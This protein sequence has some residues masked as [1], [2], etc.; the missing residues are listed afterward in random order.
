VPA[1][2]VEFENTNYL[3]MAKQYVR[4][5]TPRG[6]HVFRA[7]DLNHS[8]QDCGVFVSIA[9]LKEHTTAGVTLFEEL[10]WHHTLHDLR[11]WRR[12]KGTWFAAAGRPRQ[13]CMTLRGSL[14]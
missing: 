11:R 8:D 3:G 6:G 2:L 14:P 13:F 10:L 4:L 1:P 9:K 7:F 12:G 5:A